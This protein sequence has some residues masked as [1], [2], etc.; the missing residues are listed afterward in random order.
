MLYTIK[1]INLEKSYI[2][3]LEKLRSD[4]TLLSNYSNESATD[5]N[6][7]Q[8]KRNRILIGL[9]NDCQHSDYEIANFLFNEEKELRQS[10]QEIEEYEV[11]VLYLSAFILT[12]FNKV[13]D[14]WS[15]IDSKETDFDSSIGFDIEYLLSFGIDEVKKYLNDC[16]HPKREL[17]LKLTGVSNQSPPY[18]QEEINDWKRSKHEYFSVFEFPIKDEVNFSFQAKEYKRLKSLLPNWLSKKSE[19]TENQNLT[20]I[21]IGRILQLNEFHLESLKHY[22]NTFK[23]SVRNK[24]FKEDIVKLE[25]KL[26]IKRAIPNKGFMA[27]LKDWFS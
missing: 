4:K 8:I 17:A 9:Y 12:K 21:A 11:E 20:S 6:S 22:V 14:I 15:F 19:W 1:I 2:D 5:K 3:E 24:M 23:N 25:N 10:D 16:N 13:E 27:K 7:N 26:H 18:S